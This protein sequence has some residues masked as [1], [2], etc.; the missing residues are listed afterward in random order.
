LT[1]SR[2]ALRWQLRILVFAAALALPAAAHATPT[3]LAAINISDPGRDGFEPKV[4]IAPD[5]TVIAVWTRSDGTNF[6]IQSSNRTPN[7]AWATPQTVSDPG[8]SASGPT[9]AVDPSGNAV[10]AWTQSDGTNLRINAAYRPAGGS[11]S[12]STMVSAAGFDASAP[13]VSMDSAGSALVAWQRTDGTN[14]RVQAAIR[15]PGAGGGFGGISTLSDPGQDAFTPQV[16]AGPSIDANGTVVWTRSD[17][18]NLRVQSARRRDVQGYPRP[19]G[20]SPLRASLVP[21][22]NACTLPNRNHGGGLAFPSCNPPIQTS[23]VLTIGSPDANLAQANFTGFVRWAVVNG[24]PNTEANEADVKLTVNLADIRNN[25]TLTDY[26]GQVTAQTDLQITD[27]L[28]APETPEPGTMQT[29]QYQA[30]VTCVATP[31]TSIGSTCSLDTTAN[32][33]VP[34]TVLESRRTIWQFG[35]MQ[36][37]DAGLDGIRGNA[38]DTVF[39]RQGVFVP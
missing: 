26:T 23:S 17:G 22:F 14:L 27:Q 28:N 6:R 19:K 20:A 9:I 13:D 31:S 2:S 15:S 30:P 21:A 32:A 8:V 10:A 29:I 16:A 1:R 7:G 5:G 35:Q 39:L 36:I 18:T 33:L 37:K 34:G 11:F 12:A 38:D 3:F 24:N 4:V 25:P